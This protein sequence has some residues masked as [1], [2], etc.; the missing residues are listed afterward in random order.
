MDLAEREKQRDLIAFS[1]SF[2]YHLAQ[3]T[4]KL[5]L[6][7]GGKNNANFSDYKHFQSPVSPVREREAWPM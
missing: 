7:D 6:Q 1:G 3:I 2:P 5:T 4:Q